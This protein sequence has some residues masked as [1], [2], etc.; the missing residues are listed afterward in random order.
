MKHY[1][2]STQ[3]S[4][5]LKPAYRLTFCKAL[6]TAL[7]LGLSFPLSASAEEV[8]S[9][10]STSA[11]Q[12]NNTVVGVVLDS[13]T[14]EPI[15]GANVLIKGTSTGVA[16]DL[17][18][19]FQ[20][21][22]NANDVL[23]ISFLGYTP[24]EIKVGNQKVISVTLAEDAQM[25]E[26]VVVTA[27]GTGQKKET[28]TGSIQTVRPSDLKVPAANLSTAFAGRLAGV[29]AYQR[30]GAPGEN[31]ANFYIRGV[32]TMSGT[33]N[34][35]IIIDGIEASS[36]DLNALDPEVIEGF[37]VLKDATASAMYG[38]RGANG[39]L[40][41]KTKSGAD[42]DKPIIGVRVENY[43]NTP[44]KIPKLANA[45]TYMRMYNEAVTNQGTG[46]VLYSEERIRNTVNRVNPYVYPNVDWYDELFRDWTWNQRANM[47]IRGGTSKVTYF[48][49]LNVGHETGM[50]KNRSKDFFSFNNNISYM[51]YA[52]QSNVDYKV[53]NTAKLSLQLNTQLNDMHGPITASDGSGGINEIFSSIMNTNSVD[54]P[55]YF[56]Q[57]KDRWVH[58]GSKKG[59]ASNFPNPM[60]VATSGYKDQFESTVIA[61]LNYEQKLDF[62]TQ[63]LGFKAL[64]SFKNWTRSNKYRHQGHNVYELASYNVDTDGN[65]T[66]V[67]QPI[68]GGN[69]TR[70]VLGTTGGNAGDRRY[71]I[72]AYVDYNR[73][74]GN[75]NVSAMA[76]YNQDEYNTN[77]PGTNLIASL[78]K[79]RMGYA[80]RASYDYANRYMIE[81]NAGYNG[82]E[83]FA[84]GKRFGFFP[85][86]AGGWNISQ[87][88]FFE[89]YKKV[90]SNL[91]LRAS[92]GLVGNDQIG[93]TRFVYMAIVN[94][95]N[96]AAYRTGYD[97]VT[98]EHKGPTFTRLQN[99][100]IT[101]EVGK[102]LNVGLDLQLFNDFNLTIDAFQEIRSDIFQQ[103]QSIPNFFGTANTAI[104]GNYAKVKNYG[105][106]MSLDYGKQI[107]KDLSIQMKGTFTLA[108]NRVLEYD[109]AADLRPG[110]RQVG[111]TLNAIMGYVA[112]GLYIDQADIANSAK[113][114]IGNI[115][116][117]PGDIKYVDQPDAYGN[118]DG[119]IDANDRVQLGYPTVPEIVYGFGP[120]I[121]YKNWDFSFFFQGQARVS[122]MMSGFSPFGTTQ[123]RRNVLQWIAD[124]YWSPDNQNP[125]A[126]FPR[127]TEQENNHNM[128]A[129]S[130]WL[131]SAAFLKLKTVEVGYN[132]K[133]ANARVYLSANNLVTFSPFKLWDPEMGGGAGMSY[134]LQRT[135]NL[136]VQVTFK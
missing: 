82:S 46:A 31:A 59:G 84:K 23:V 92:Y 44:I 55:I 114:T 57:D 111:K 53:S 64:L 58:W 36:A 133:K 96:S 75:H 129:S 135:F 69:P 121:G 61:N 20:I 94:L 12:S 45:E 136:G 95:A 105:F 13:K 70:P 72:Q 80:F 24:K 47:N 68:G 19:K 108:R 50:L 8:S 9:A 38:T 29:V 106:D 41:I 99:N 37:S 119:Q 49:N 18:G 35:L 33:T 102:K 2:N 123:S 22:A 126:R 118:Y 98:E 48:L 28:V 73:S 21:R 110:M 10:S 43:V 79:R 113:S 30:S 1:S 63:G 85:S 32:S 17:D 74:F 128:A 83:N 125:N 40:I 127:L 120:S 91:K 16:T 131:R 81:V 11:Q 26:Q 34:P 7:A 88:P 56:P 104:F 86:I 101:W 78:P 62:I 54:F 97:G 117:A 93:N 14:N 109:E 90:V 103:K 42:L 107:N 60:A 130:H 15:I 89:K 87:E 132:F 27:F 25:L 3:S 112:D 51:K 39:V 67:D 6:C 116:I 5:K 134:P 76:L 115:A 65:Y 66:I 122:L 4:A 124:D 52:F 100:N 71:Y 77:T